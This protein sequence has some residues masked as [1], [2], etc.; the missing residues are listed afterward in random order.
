MPSFMPGL[1]A[2]CSSFP[3]FSLSSFPDNSHPRHPGGYPLPW[4]L[5]CSD[6]SRWGVPWHHRWSPV[7]KVRSPVNPRILSAWHVDDRRRE[8]QPL[9]GRIQPLFSLLPVTGE[10]RPCGQGVAALCQSPQK[11]GV[12][13]IFFSFRSRNFLPALIAGVPHFTPLHP[14]SNLPV[15]P[16]RC[17]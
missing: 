5:A 13:F 14:P 6:R 9:S 7:P 3:G 11:N 10:Y 17:H 4:P 2:V 12:F 8:F 15:S 1:P 16:C